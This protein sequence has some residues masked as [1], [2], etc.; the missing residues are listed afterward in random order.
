MCPIELAIKSYTYTNTKF[1][2]YFPESE[3]V[4]AIS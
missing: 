2:K 1:E 4:I 3:A